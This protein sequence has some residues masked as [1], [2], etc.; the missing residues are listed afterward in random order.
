MPRTFIRSA[1]LV[2]V[3]VGTG[4]AFLAAQRIDDAA[5]NGA[6][7]QRGDWPTYGLDYAETRYSPL[8]QINADNADRL[9]RAWSVEIGV[10]GGGQE[11][12]PLAANGVLYSITNWSVAFAVDARSGK[13]LWRW[14]PRV[15]HVID[16]VQT[17]RVC[18]GAVNRGVALYNGK[19]IVPVLDGRLAALDAATGNVLWEVR[20]TPYDQPY[21]LTMAPRIVKNKII[22]GGAGGEFFV[23]GYVS[24]F[25]VETGK[26]LW[27]F[28]T[29]PG[30]P[31]KPFE[32]DAMRRAAATWSGDWWKLGG[33]GSIW[34]GL[35]YDPDLDLIYV[36]TGN[37]TPWPEELRHSKGLDNLY[38]CSILAIK[39]DTGQL[40]WHYQAV[41]GDSWDYDSV[42]QLTLADMTIGGRVR[43][44]IMQANKDGFF[45]VLDRATG[46]FISAAPFARVSWASGFD[47]KTGRPIINPEARYETKPV[48]VAPS[49]AHS[50]AP[51]AFNPNTGLIYLPA[52]PDGS[53]V[54]AVNRDFVPTPGL[55]AVVRVGVA[56]GGAANAIEPPSIGPA[57]IAGQRGV[58][59]AWDP[60]LQKERWRA[61]GGGGTGGGA[62]TTAG[63]LVFQVRQDGHLLAY[64]AD[65]GAKVLDVQTELGAGMG[66]P[67]TYLV[68]GKQYVAF[69]GNPGGGAARGAAAPATPAAP[70]LLSF[71]LGN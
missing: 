15:D 36:G 55:P 70:K 8:N 49:S 12:T 52:T 2:F 22:I 28:Y 20:A 16:A 63:N 34:D 66:P 23:R 10:G 13:E 18:C 29:V 24:A 50:W 26:E 3:L 38:I 57:T 25:D 31:S 9:A 7:K 62:L 17:D 53:F 59:L 61:D 39:P 41:P 58:L 67:I 21:T 69:M 5:L 71:T 4:F 1:L 44:V 46:E 37:G 33:G 68:D 65:N 54:Y 35:S 45:Y 56:T 30:D 60:V 48:R 64:R 42:Q 51:M 32:N 11:A 6:G 14:D 47:P 40:A 43:K 19:V 27:R